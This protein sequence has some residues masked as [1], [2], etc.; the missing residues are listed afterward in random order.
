MTKK[1]TFEAVKVNYWQKKK[2][3]FY[4]WQALERKAQQGKAFLMNYEPKKEI[5]ISEPRFNACWLVCLTTKGTI[6]KIVLF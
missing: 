4:M 6:K 2:I 3:T 1:A 5:L